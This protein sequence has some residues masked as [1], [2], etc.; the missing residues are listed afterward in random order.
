MPL[1]SVNMLPGRTLEQKQAMIRE[2]TDAVV[3]TCDAK[4]ESVW[5]TVT[6]VP[7]E[8]WGVAGKP[9]G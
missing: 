5:V 1:I 7:G 2:V 6:E 8:H 4:P 9:L 3:R